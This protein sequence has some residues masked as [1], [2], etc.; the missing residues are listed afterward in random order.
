M[1]KL[2]TYNIRVGLQEKKLVET[3]GK[4]AQQ[5]AQVFC[6]QE[7]P[8]I[9]G[10]DF[11]GNLFLGS[12]GQSWRG[13]FSPLPGT[14]SYHLG[15]GII[16]NSNFL[17]FLGSQTVLLPKFEQPKLWEL[18]WHKIAHAYTETGSWWRSFFRVHEPFEATQR[19]ALICTFKYG[20]ELLR[21]TVLHLDWY[22]SLAQRSR[23]IQHLGEVL[24]GQP[25]VDKEV[26]CGD[27]NTLGM[28]IKFKKRSGEIQSVL[29]PGF[30]D[31]L[32]NPRRTGWPFQR[33]DYIFAKGFKNYQGKVNYLRGS[34]H[35]P[36][37][38]ELE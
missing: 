26:I 23:Q 4:L 30:I 7:L 10:E 2:V 1:L 28:F 34:D 17:E 25:P 6:L 11:I 5:G 19:A 8:K 20:G 27:F 13:E 21:V 12:L 16:W 14:R 38:A 32:K 36:V 37:S 31:T 9:D 29:P 3:V 15:L 22:G 18:F 33:L 35:K 24:A